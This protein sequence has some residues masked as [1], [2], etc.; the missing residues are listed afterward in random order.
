MG[1]TYEHNQGEDFKHLPEI[2]N[3]EICSACNL[4]C[5]MCLR[6][7]HL[8]RKPGLVDLELLRKMHERGD[9][10]GTIYTELQMAGEPTLHP[11]LRQIIRFLRQEVGILVGLS[12]HGLTIKEKTYV[13]DALL[14]LDALTISVDSVDPAT[15]HQMRYPGKIEDLIECLDIFFEAMRGQME[16]SEGL[17][18]PFVELQ[19]VKTPLAA[20]SGNVEALQ[21][22]VNE[23]GW[24]DLC[25]IRTI[26]DCFEGMQGRPVDR[27]ANHDL[28]L[29]PFTSVSVAHTGA[30]VSCCMIFTPKI[31][32]MNYYG[33]LNEQSLKEI[34]EGPRVWK[35]RK[36]HLHD[37]SVAGKSTLPDQ[38]AVCTS[39]SP[40]T[41]HTQIV[42][43]L[44]RLRPQ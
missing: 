7:T 11:Q 33:N 13:L 19:L 2:A 35:M 44:V 3:I 1:E 22:L 34:W 27:P 5:P 4:Q 24:N 31:E 12:T 25:S 41:I 8:G 14:E 16:A 30:V 26:Y 28:C 15:Y 20:G 18:I 39:K 17:R 36:S 37:T 40:C 32:E 23:R 21:K 29:N 6:T 9:F 10:Q 42:S 43:R 38:C